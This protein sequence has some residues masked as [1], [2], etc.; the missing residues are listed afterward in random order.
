[1]GDTPGTQSGGTQTG[2]GGQNLAEE[3]MRAVQ[4]FMGQQAAT[5]TGQGATKALRTVINKIGRFDGKNVTMFLRTYTCEMEIYQVPGEKMIETFYHAVVPEIREKVR[6]LHEGLLVNTW[7]AFE[8]RLKDE[9]FDEDTERMSKRGFLDW[10]EQ[11]PGEHMG[12]NELLREF[13]KKFGQLPLVERRILEVRKSELFLQAADEALEDRL[14]L[15][16]QDGTAEGGFTTNWR[17]LEEGVSLIAKQQRMKARGFGARMDIAPSAIHTAS[18]PVVPTST[19]PSSSIGKTVNDATL[20]EL[21][22]GIRELKVEM[23]ALKRDTKPSASQP[24]GGQRDF[25]A[26]CIWCDDPGHKRGDCGLYADAMKNGIITFK[27]GRIRDATT[28]EILNTNFGRGGMKKLMEDRLRKGKSLQSKDGETYN[29]EVEHNK[30]RTSSHISTELMVRGAQAI[31]EL[32]GW[33]DPVDAITIRAYLASEQEVEVPSD[34][35]VEVKRG[36]D[37][38]EETIEPVSKKKASSGKDTTPGQG[39]ANHTRQRQEAGPS[40]LHPGNAPLPKDKW[41]ERMSGKKGREDP[42]KGK[43][44]APAYKLQS[45]IE[46]SIDMKGILEERILDAKIEFT[47]REALGIAKKDFH[48]LII[49][50]IKRKRQ[51]TV[52][53]VMVKAL[54]THMT[55]DE[56]EEIGQ[57]FTMMCDT[58]NI[59]EEDNE[60]VVNLL[61][62][63]MEDEVLQMF[64]PGLVVKRKEEAKTEILT[65]EVAITCC[66]GGEFRGEQE[67][68]EMRTYTKPYWARATTETHVKLGDLNEAILALVDHGSEINIISRKIYEKGKWPIDINHGWVLRAA[69]NEKGGLYGACPAV[70]TKIGDVEVEQNFFVQNNG[71]YPII[72]GQPYIT[73]TRM[74]TKVLDDGSHY[75]RIRSSDGKRAVQFLTVKPNHKRHRA[76]LREAPVL[77]EPDDFQGF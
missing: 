61:D 18:T 15:F 36:R 26:R 34:A 39:P 64:S 46:S 19:S 48:E 17:R 60:D 38:E 33:D 37:E 16:L 21:I 54:D 56:E 24:V 29:I 13:E 50:I 44:K 63:E 52:E 23:N 5:I 45:D 40:T 59:I 72:L 62:G 12:S 68:E 66:M 3:F 7:A 4:M 41:E 30:E 75:A 14:L 6:Q 77:D 31:R 69:N 43:G 70:K 11:R 35:L 67:S 20:Q 1:M 74:G 55:E 73:A 8:E 2:G 47:L 25:V 51:M 58:T 42:A 57:V 9:Y 53:T 76:Q 49:D 10:V 32:T 65:G 22:K 28:E 27:E 71:T